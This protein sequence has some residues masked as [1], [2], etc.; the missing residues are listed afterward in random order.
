VT[1]VT[2]STNQHNADIRSQQAFDSNSTHLVVP[3]GPLGIP[4]TVAAEPVTAA[5]LRSLVRSTQRQPSQTSTNDDLLPLGETLDAVSHRTEAGRL[6]HAEGRGRLIESAVAIRRGADGCRSRLLVGVREQR[7]VAAHGGED[8]PS[9]DEEW[10][11]E[12]GY[13]T[14]GLGSVDSPKSSGEQTLVEE[15][16]KGRREGVCEALLGAIRIFPGQKHSRG[17]CGVGCRLRFAEV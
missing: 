2:Y 15:E 9:L 17:P 16:K 13:E 6:A 4:R 7:R 8:S 14:G 5:T 3:L 11:V 1:V 10:R 12:Y